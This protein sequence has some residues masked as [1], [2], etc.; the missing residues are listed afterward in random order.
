MTPATK[1]NSSQMAPAV[2]TYST[3]MAVKRF[4]GSW[5]LKYGAS[6]AL[7]WTA[8]AALITTEANAANCQAPPFQAP[9]SKVP[10]ST[11]SIAK[12]YG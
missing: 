5:T 7:L 3:S 6:G 8:T 2:S 10:T 4:H 1:R 9:K 12:S 11:A